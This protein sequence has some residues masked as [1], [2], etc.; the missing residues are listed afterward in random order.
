MELEL[1]AFETEYTQLT[2]LK[3]DGKDPEGKNR[4][5]FSV[6]LSSTSISEF[7]CTRR[8]SWERPGLTIAV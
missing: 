8:L 2:D 5:G 7:V 4:P 1:R 3:G 6:L